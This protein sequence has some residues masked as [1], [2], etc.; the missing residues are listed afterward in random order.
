MFGLSAFDLARIQFAFTVS[1]HIIFPA[2]TI[3]LAS[4]LAVLEGLWLKTRNKDYL[5]LFHFWSKIFAVNFAMG[6]VSGLV[7]A[8]QF[9]TNWSFFSDFAGSITGPLLTY[10]VLTAFF[11]EAGFLG[12]MLFGWNKVGEKLHFFATCMVALGTLMSTFWILAS[13]S[14]MQTPQGFEI[15]NNQVVLVDWLAVIFNP[16]F[17]YRLAHM[18]VA[19]FLASAFFIAASASWHLLK[20]NKTS[21]MKKMLSM[22]IWIILILAPIQALIGDM[23]G[24]N[25]LKHQPAKIAAIEGHWQNNPGEATPLILFGIPNM[26]EE[27]TKYALQIPYLG[28]L[29]LTHSLDKQVPALKEFPKDDR[30]NSLIVFWSFRIM[31]GLG[32]LMILVG[33]WGT[34]LRYKKKLY[35]SNLFLR[36]TFLM[37]PSGLIAILAGWFT[38]EVGRQPWVVYGI[39]R[40]RDAVSAHGEMH[41]SISLLIFFIVYGS[42][43]G[44]G[45]A[46]MLK[47]IRKGAPE[48]QD[49]N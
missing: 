34:W 8:Y 4:F 7:M 3:G 35:Q 6:V 33:V 39:Q 18:G 42:V 40:T 10:E 9:G 45:Y 14:W 48:V 20:G 36:F 22:S 37:A 17:P 41:M 47:L 31:V 21:A 29:I 16:S 30:P 26:D 24:L 11:L 13:N 32:M 2:I 28:S 43:F 19:A 12:V 27:K 23:H 25:T 49:G 1:F 5:A 15:V 44:I 46:Y 38:T